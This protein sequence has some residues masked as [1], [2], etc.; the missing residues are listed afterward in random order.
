MTTRVFRVDLAEERR[1]RALNDSE[2]RDH[3]PVKMVELTPRED[4]DLHLHL[5]RKG[6]N[7]R[8]GENHQDAEIFPQPHDVVALQPLDKDP[9]NHR[10]REERA[11]ED[12]TMGGQD[13]PVSPKDLDIAPEIGVH[14]PRREKEKDESHS[15]DVLAVLPSLKAHA[16]RISKDVVDRAMLG[17]KGYDPRADAERPSSSSSAGSRGDR[18]SFDRSPEHEDVDQQNNIQTPEHDQ[19]SKEEFIEPSDDY[20]ADEHPAPPESPP[21]PP[22]P[23]PPPLETRAERDAALMPPPNAPRGPRGDMPSIDPAL[24]PSPIDTSKGKVRFSLGGGGRGGRFPTAPRNQELSL[25]RRALGT[26]SNSVPVAPRKHGAPA[27]TSTPPPPPPPP[28]PKRVKKQ[29]VWPRAIISKFSFFDRLGLVGEGTYGKV[30]KAKNRATGEMVALKRVRMNSERDGFP[31]TAVREIKILQKLTKD[32]DSE[33]LVHLLDNMVEDNNF[34]MIFDY[35]DHDLTGILNHPQYRL[36]TANIK[37]LAQQFFKGLD[38][39]HRK[40]ILHRDIKGSN[41]LLNNQG[42]LK[43]A[44]FGLARHYEKKKNDENYTNRV[45]TL[46]YRP[47]EILLGETLY[48]TAPDIWSAGCV[49]MELF[50]RKAIFQGKDEIN[51]LDIIWSVLGTPKVSAWPGWR[52]TAWYSMLRPENIRPTIFNEKYKD[53][54]PSDALALANRIFVYDPDKRPSAKEVLEDPYF[55]N[56]PKPERAVTIGALQGDWHEYESKGR[57]KK[58]REQKKAEQQHAAQQARARQ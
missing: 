6:K 57:R 22:P 4:T 46:W 21:P 34:F 28:P 12:L 47:V 42:L 50:T 20:D 43:I 55:T 7:D 18:Q 44:D 30:Y 45:I 17:P 54:L 11:N 48:K 5:P 36:E 51:Q 16:K 23:P 24:K 8:G 41:I 27:H 49:F 26:S 38:F 25:M 10:G 52:K 15:E 3:H 40:G 31:I 14:P 56:D 58:E 32:R 1:L 35:M 29:L 9:V 2:N 39:I 37:D 53:I 13:E 33:N 19:I